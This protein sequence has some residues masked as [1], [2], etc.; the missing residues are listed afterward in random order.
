[1]RT[2][3]EEQR[4]RKRIAAMDRQVRNGSLVI[5]QMTKSERERHP[6]VVSDAN[7]RP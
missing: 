2:Q 4:R 7:R 5:R 1:M 3:Q 6:A